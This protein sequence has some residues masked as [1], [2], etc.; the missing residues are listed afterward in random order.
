MH[1]DS[2]ISD[3]EYFEWQRV[4]HRIDKICLAASQKGVKVLI[5]AEET[6]IQNGINTLADKMMARFNG[7]EA[8]VY[9][10]FQ[11]Y[12][13]GALEYLK[14]S[15][16]LAK[17]KSYI[18]GVKI[19]R[20]AYM[21]KERKRAQKFDYPDPI[22]ATKEDTDK[23]FNDALELSLYNINSVGLFIGT[24]NETSCLKAIQL[25]ANL[26]I[27]S[28]TDRVYFSQ[29]YGMSDNISFN[30]AQDG[31]RVAKYLPYG[32]VEEVIPYLMRRAQENT[33][34]AGQTTRELVLISKELKRRKQSCTI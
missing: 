17:K 28:C 3:S 31:Y 6:W 19:V 29:L 4:D 10:T 12:T 13:K 26:G 22:Q 23:D 8:I 1:N 7:S 18:L 16:E 2:S 27:Q 24:H 14:E 34:V 20:G 5:D 25:M 21:E 9:N 33:S 11:M 15:I 32:P 30:L